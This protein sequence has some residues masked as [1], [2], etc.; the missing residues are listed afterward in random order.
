MFTSLAFLLHVVK[1]QGFGFARTSNFHFPN[2]LNIAYTALLAFGT[3][4][5]QGVKTPLIEVKVTSTV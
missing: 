5:Q 3:P 2:H 4:V 1:P